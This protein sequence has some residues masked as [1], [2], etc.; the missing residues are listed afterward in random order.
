MIQLYFL[1]TGVR[2]VARAP[3]V[4]PMQRHSSA[5]AS[6]AR[7]ITWPRQTHGIS[8]KYMFPCSERDMPRQCA[9]TWHLQVV[10]RGT[11]H[12]VRWRQSLN[13]KFNRAL[14]ARDK[15]GN[16]G[17][18]ILFKTRCIWSPTMYQEVDTIFSLVVPDCL[19][20]LQK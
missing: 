15:F 20:C 11:H 13:Q 17:I 6:R 3:H 18:L 2:V 14:Q 19:F 1:N 16:G 9:A 4:H 12:A 7:D 8:L 10:L 5:S